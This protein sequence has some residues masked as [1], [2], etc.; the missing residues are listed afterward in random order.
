MKKAHAPVLVI[1]AHPDDEV[2]GCGGTIGWHTKQGHEVHVLVLGEGATSRG[3]DPRGRNR[4]KEVRALDRAVR[5][6]ARDLGVKE[7]HRA[8]FPDNRFD[9][10]DLLDVVKAVEQVVTAVRPGRIYT[11]HAGDLNIDHRIVHQA[12][13]TAARPQPNSAVT[14]VLAFE[15]P[16]S[17]E[18][19]GPGSHVPFWP[20]VY[21]DVTETL[22]QKLAALRC[23]QSELRP[24]PHPRSL[25]SVE[26]IAKRWGVNVGL[27][28]AEAFMLVREVVRAR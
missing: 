24:Y 10:V 25:E 17:T 20:Q 13:L 6:A 18:W 5:E 28:A 1:A 8:H 19:Q 22:P 23:Y 7:V 2:L 15:V 27:K 4:V 26:I 12:V 9:S 3:S 14:T 11:H 21:V 16:S